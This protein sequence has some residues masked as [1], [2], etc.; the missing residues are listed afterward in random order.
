MSSRRLG[1]PFFFLPV[2]L[3]SAEKFITESVSL[4]EKYDKLSDKLSI[5][6]DKEKSSMV[7]ARNKVRADQL[8]EKI[9][10]ATGGKPVKKLTP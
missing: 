3:F 6:G 4:L 7:A 8:K 1:L 9:T 10:R 2:A 5:L